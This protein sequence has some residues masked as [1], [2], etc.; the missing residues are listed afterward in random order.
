MLIKI[1]FL[2]RDVVFCQILVEISANCKNIK[3]CGI[4]DLLG[5][6]AFMARGNNFCR[7]LTEISGIKK[8]VDF[9]ENQR[10]VEENCLQWANTTF[11]NL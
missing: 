3:M 8:N 10:F 9:L 7:N 5:K 2:A 1:K 4:T 6:I 11:C